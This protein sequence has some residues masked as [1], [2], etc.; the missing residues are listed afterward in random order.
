M[1]KPYR[2][3]FVKAIA[4]EYEDLANYVLH[5]KFVTNENTQQFH[6]CKK[7]MK[8]LSELQNL[9]GDYYDKHETVSSNRKTSKN[10]R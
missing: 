7:A 4:D 8:L 1:I 5:I 9:Y 10:K 2:K 3:S 6:D